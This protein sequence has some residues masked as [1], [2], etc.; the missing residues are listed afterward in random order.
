MT[1]AKRGGVPY[2]T[3]GKNQKSNQFL[4][5]NYQLFLPFARSAVAYCLFS[6]YVYMLPQVYRQCAV[7]YTDF[8]SGY[9]EIFPSKGH[10]TLGK[11]TRSTSYI[12]LLNNTLCQRISPL[13]RKTIS[14]SKKLEN[15]IGAICYFIHHNAFLPV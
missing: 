6:G 15:N 7:C 5:I 11:E 1:F 12:E 10:Q 14:F 3:Y 13:L 8:W 2:Y 4:S 9:Q